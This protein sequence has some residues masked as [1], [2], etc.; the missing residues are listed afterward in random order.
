MKEVSR[1]AAISALLLACAGWTRATASPTDEPPAQEKAAQAEGADP[2]EEP[3]GERPSLQAAPLPSDLVL[4]GILSEAAWAEAES[5]ENLTTVEPEEGGAPAGR[6]TVKVLANAKEIVF[7]VV[8]E[9]AEP[10]GIVSFSK[11]RD[12]ELDEEDHILVVLD[13]FQDGRSGYAFA[14]N[15]SGA[16]F[17]GLVV[18]QGEEVKPE[19]GR[20]VGGADVAEWRGLER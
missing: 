14:V 13:T 20:G 10:A 9:D 2:A 15:P 12:S 17:D 7:G 6:T 4:D 1:A 11:A 8:C 3:Q 19:L 18:A 5:I 16:R